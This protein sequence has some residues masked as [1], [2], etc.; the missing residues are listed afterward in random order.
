MCIAILTLPGKSISRPTFDRC[1]DNNS[2]GFGMAVI[3][4][5]TKKVEIH[6]GFLDKN[7]ALSAYNRAVQRSGEYPMAL[8]FRAATVGGVNKDNCHPFA[9]KGGAMVHNGTFWY[10]NAAKKS[11]SRMLAEIMHNQL[12]HANLTKFKTNYDKAFGYN[13][14]IF[15]FDEGK[16][17]IF[18][19]EY[20]GQMGKFGQWADGIWYSNGGWFGT[21][22]GDYSDKAQAGPLNKFDDDD[23]MAALDNWW[24]G[25]NRS[26]FRS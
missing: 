19:E 9:V 11:D 13:R 3:N 2:H 23:E 5:E 21:Y 24:N 4:P 26:T 15:L 25:R 20:N 14:V 16:Y 10:D 1:W 8:H 6:K 22:N 17:V 7:L 18:S 12:T